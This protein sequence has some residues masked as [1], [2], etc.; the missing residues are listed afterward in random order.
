MVTFADQVAVFNLNYG[1]LFT[2]AEISMTNISVTE[3][4]RLFQHPLESGANV[5]DYS[6][7]EP[8]KLRIKAILPPET[9]FSTYSQL[10]AIYTL[11]STLYVKT[12]VRIYQNL[13]IESMPHEETVSRLQSV[14]MELSLREIQYASTIFEYVPI[15]DRDQNV[16]NRGRQTSTP[17]VTAPLI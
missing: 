2:D 14:D 12:R 8:V 3:N 6:I 9:Y 10:N 5:V 13:I 7:I 4:R 11:G 15:S 17:Q 16:V 1:R